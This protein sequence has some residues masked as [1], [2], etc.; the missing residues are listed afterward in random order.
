MAACGISREVAAFV[1]YF[2]RYEARAARLNPCRMSTMVDPLVACAH[3]PFNC[4]WGKNFP[5]ISAWM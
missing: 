4:R 3:A 2:A 5:S 1:A